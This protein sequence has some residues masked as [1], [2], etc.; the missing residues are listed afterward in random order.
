MSPL[1]SSVTRA[2][3]L[4]AIVWPMIALGYRC[5]GGVVSRPVR[6][7]RRRWAVVRLCQFGLLLWGMLVLGPP[8]ARAEERMAVPARAMEMTAVFAQPSYSPGEP[9]RLR[10]VADATRLTV[11]PIAA[12]SSS[13]NPYAPIADDPAVG[14]ARTVAWRPGAGTVTVRI[15]RLASGVYFVRV[16]SARRQVVAPVVV[17]PAHLGKAPV[18]VVV[19]TYTWQAYNRRGGDSWYVC[20]CVHTVDLAR[21]YLDHGVPYNFGQ[22]D[23]N[24]LRWLAQKRVRVDVLADSDFDRIANGRELRRLYRMVVF[25]GHSEYVTRHMFDITEQYRDV[26]GHLAFLSANNFFREVVVSGYS[27]TLIGAFRNLGRPEAALVGAGY[28]D[29]YRN[30]YRN[31]PYRVVGARRVRWLFAHTG[32]KD[33]S[34]LPGYYG[35]EIDGRTAASPRGTIVLAMIRDIFPGETAEMTYYTTHAG[36]EVFDA[37]TINFGGAAGNPDVAKMLTNLWTHMAGMTLRAP[38][39]QTSAGGRTSG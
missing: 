6:L 12:F 16:R 18:A 32:L 30:R 8:V 3:I 33:G 22:Y 17:R 31:R 10:V 2:G 13:G 23:R 14:R 28:I 26:G 34:L 37:G 27:M 39:N 7:S 9:A 19:P 36:A 4:N 20:W 21:P 24:F 25:E 15:G 38:S 11:Q 5:A 1:H 35:I 29:W